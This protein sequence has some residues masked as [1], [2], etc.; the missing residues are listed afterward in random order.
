MKRLFCVTSYWSSKPYIIDPTWIKE[1]QASEY[2]VENR[3]F[4]NK[5]LAKLY[6]NWLGNVDRA[7]SELK[8]LENETDPR[9][10]AK[11]HNKIMVNSGVRV[12]YGP[13]H[14]RSVL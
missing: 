2:V 6:R 8:K 4:S 5:E 3:Y 11:M 1:N 13:D 7:L 12:S 9:T 10:L 14:Y